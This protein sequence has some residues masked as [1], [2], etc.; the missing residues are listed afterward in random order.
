MGHTEG[1]V[2]ETTNN[3]ITSRPEKTEQDGMFAAMEEKFEAFTYSGHLSGYASGHNHC[4]LV[5]SID[6]IYLSE[7]SRGQICRYYDKW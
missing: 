7:P 5:F 4:G 2:P 6:T 1:L 3:T